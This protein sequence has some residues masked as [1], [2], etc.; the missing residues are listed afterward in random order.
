MTVTQALAT[1]RRLYTILS[2]T[3]NTVDSTQQH[4]YA[5]FGDGSDT[6]DDRRLKIVYTIS[7]VDNSTTA[8]N[9]KDLS[10]STTQL[11]RRDV[12]K[13]SINPVQHSHSLI[14]SS[15]SSIVI[16]CCK[17]KVCLHNLQKGGEGKHC[18]SRLT[19]S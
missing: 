5:P 9:S 2:R 3:I 16:S 4:T 1:F 6:I 11:P 7:D 15:T 18:L 12:V 8:P 17:L 13:D 14:L 19:R 10:S